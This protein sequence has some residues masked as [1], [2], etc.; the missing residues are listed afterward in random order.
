MPG[1]GGPGEPCIVWAVMGEAGGS[2]RSA[3][4][5]TPVDG[6][7]RR[8]PSINDAATALKVDVRTLSSVFNED[9]QQKTVPNAE[10]VRYTGK[11]ELARCERAR[12]TDLPPGWT[13]EVRHV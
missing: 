6:T 13:S 5:M 7:E 8:F 11:W 10:G 12:P 4:Y 3:A 2:Q 1:G 9:K